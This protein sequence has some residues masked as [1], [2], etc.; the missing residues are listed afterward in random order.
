[1]LKIITS[2]LLVT[3]L[4]GCASS[5]PPPLF[6][7]DGARNVRVAKSDPPD[8]Y[9]EVGQVSAADGKG[10]GG[11]GY[12][13]T[14]ERVMVLLKNKAYQMGADYIQLFTISEPRLVDECF[15]NQYKISG[16][17]YKKN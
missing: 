11:F 5:T 3:S 13:G 14:Y 2:L 10:C 8:S 16:T 7:L 4:V 9:K 12:T 6:L 1:M 15:V 17:A